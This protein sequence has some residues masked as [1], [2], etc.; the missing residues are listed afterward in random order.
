MP[1]HHPRPFVLAAVLAG[2]VVAVSATVFSWD[3]YRASFGPRTPESGSPAEGVYRAASP[4]FSGTEVRLEPGGRVEITSPD[5]EGSS[6]LLDPRVARNPANGEW[7]WADRGTRVGILR[8]RQATAG[9]A[10]VVDIEM[11]LTPD[12][13]T[14]YIVKGGGHRGAIRAHGVTELDQ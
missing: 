1:R 8:F 10:P 3:P 2:L 5:P 13:I 4:L 9:E 6:I 7:F 11:R 12:F 14:L